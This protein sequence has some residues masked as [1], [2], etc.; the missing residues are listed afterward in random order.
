[1]V[2]GTDGRG[3]LVTSWKLG[4]KGRK[5]RMKRRRVRRKQRIDVSR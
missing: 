2:G 1:M 4:K 5:R 3:K